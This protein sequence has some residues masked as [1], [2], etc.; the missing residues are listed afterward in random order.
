MSQLNVYLK[1]KRYMPS[2]EVAALNVNKGHY[3]INMN[4]PDEI[5]LK[6]LQRFN[7]RGENILFRP[8][9][10]SEPYYMLADDLD[11]ESINRHGRYPD[12][13]YR[14]GRLIVETSPKN[15]QMWVHFDMPVSDDEKRYYLSI[16]KADPGADP[17]HRF[18]RL[19]GFTNRWARHQRPDG[20]Y[21]MARLIWVDWHNRGRKPM[22]G[23]S[24]AATDAEQSKAS[25]SSLL[26]IPHRG[27]V[28]LSILRS[29]IYYEC[30]DESRTDFRYVLYL[31]RRGCSDREEAIALLKGIKL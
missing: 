20:S 15:F 1:I 12:R 5:I 31:I 10:D 13:S 16:M 28:C 27:G 24:L 17:K 14:P 26:S 7:T 9:F 3:L 23:T 29:R 22:N 25:S 2:L 21:P 30:G 19:P 8:N 18:G 11:Q 4:R 6:E